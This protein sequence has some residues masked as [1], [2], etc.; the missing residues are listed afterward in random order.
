[1]VPAEIIDYPKQ[2]KFAQ[3]LA[4]FV[5]TRVTDATNFR[6]GD[7]LR[8][9]HDDYLDTLEHALLGYRHV[10]A[11]IQQ[12]LILLCQLLFTHETQNSAQVTSTRLMSAVL[13]RLSRI[14]QLETSRR[15]GFVF[16]EQRMSVIPNF[17]L[18]V[19]Q[20]FKGRHANTPV[21]PAPSSS[22]EP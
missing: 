20:T 14:V 9:L 2:Y 12:D 15:N 1:M 8:F 22:Q 5:T 21:L 10:G 18:D 19:H 16:I 13:E 6:C 7:W 17:A 11:E 3:L 4:H